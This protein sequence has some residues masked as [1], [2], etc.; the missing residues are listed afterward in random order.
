MKFLLDLELN[1]GISV[2]L[3]MSYRYGCLFCYHHILLF[4]SQ[5]WVTLS[6]IWWVGWALN[7]YLFILEFTNY[8]YNDGEIEHLFIYGMGLRFGFNIHLFVSCIWMVPF[9]FKFALKQILTAI[10]QH[11]TKCVYQV[12]L[13][14][15][16]LQMVLP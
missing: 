14:R 13:L 9:S 4:L 5:H 1:N 12:F 11:A 15:I 10:G 3:M 2:N 16:Y 8:T 7:V 6:A